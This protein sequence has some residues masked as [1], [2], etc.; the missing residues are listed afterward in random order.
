MHHASGNEE[1]TGESIADCRP[2]TPEEADV[3][4]LLPQATSLV[5]ISERSVLPNLRGSSALCGTRSLSNFF[6][7]T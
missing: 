3:Q 4:I 1:G 6:V 5:K 2:K 7:G